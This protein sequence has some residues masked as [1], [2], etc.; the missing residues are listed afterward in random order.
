MADE[1]EKV[2]AAQP[3]PSTKGMPRPKGQLT[4]EERRMQDVLEDDD[5]REALK[6]LHSQKAK[7]G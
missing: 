6:E 1:Q 3:V 4:D 5:V 7:S 2:V